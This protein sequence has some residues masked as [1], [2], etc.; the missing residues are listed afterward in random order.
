MHLFAAAAAEV[1]SLFLNENKK[2]KLHKQLS[3]AFARLRLAYLKLPHITNINTYCKFLTVAA[4]YIEIALLQKR[5]HLQK[6]IK[7]KVCTSRTK[8]ELA[9]W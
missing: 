6:Q 2:I 7:R 8:N 1:A 3:L 4:C 5:E 9:K